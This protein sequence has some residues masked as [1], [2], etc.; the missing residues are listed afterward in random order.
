MD[1][2]AKPCNKSPIILLF[3]NCLFHCS[4]NECL[5]SDPSPSELLYAA[6]TR[7]RLENCETYFFNRDTDVKMDIL[8][9]LQVS[10][11]AYKAHSRWLMYLI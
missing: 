1:D 11:A 6:V 8:A 10:V 3:C 4:L 9:L 5:E 2:G 7:H